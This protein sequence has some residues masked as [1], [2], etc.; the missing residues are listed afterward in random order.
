MR[1]TTERS[2]ERLRTGFA[3]GGVAAMFWGRGT[4][5]ERK[6]EVKKKEERSRKKRCGAG[7]G[8]GWGGLSGKRTQEVTPLRGA[9][10]G[11]R[12]VVT[13]A[14]AAHARAVVHV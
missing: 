2:K 11:E 8:K 14:R 7:G 12:D 13:A 9:Q 6:E 10:A 3:T 5:R 4:K 1:R